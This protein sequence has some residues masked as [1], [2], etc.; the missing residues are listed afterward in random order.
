M[1]GHHYVLYLDTEHLKKSCS[2]NTLAHIY[3][4]L[5]WKGG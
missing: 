5:E 4:I 1:V 2:G 3:H